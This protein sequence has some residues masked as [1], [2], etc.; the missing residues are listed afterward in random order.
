MG[1]HGAAFLKNHVGY[2]SNYQLPSGTSDALNK[3]SITVV[4]TTGNNSG[5]VLPG[6]GA[7]Y[8]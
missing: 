8:Q 4:K 7:N 5:L 1:G 2:N 6:G 3:S